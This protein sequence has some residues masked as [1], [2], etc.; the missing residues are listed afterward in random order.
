MDAIV[1][2]LAVLA[3]AALHEQKDNIKHYWNK[4]LKGL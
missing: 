4:F 1:I 3:G 2:L